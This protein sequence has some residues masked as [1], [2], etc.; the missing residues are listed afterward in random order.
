VNGI[1]IPLGNGE[2]FWAVVRGEVDVDEGP[3]GEVIVAEGGRA[4]EVEAGYLALPLPEDL[5]QRL[6]EENAFV[7]HLFLFRNRV[8]LNLNKVP[9]VDNESIEHD[10][11]VLRGRD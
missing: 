3:A 11:A 7:T 4:V 1:N 10:V 8:H 2:L 6:I 5:P 9:V